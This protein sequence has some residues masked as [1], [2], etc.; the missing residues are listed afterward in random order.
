MGW[1]LPPTGFFKLNTDG[2]ACGSLGMA[3]AGG[4]I[5]DSKGVWVASFNRGIGLTHALVAELWGL[6]DGLALAKNLNIKYLFVETDAQAVVNIINSHSGTTTSH[7]PHIALI[8]NCRSLLQY[9]EEVRISHIHRERNHCEDIL[10]KKGLKLSNML[11]LHSSTPSCIL[12]QLLADAWGVV[13]PHSSIS[14]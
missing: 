5:K 2:F 1:T 3:S 13:Y 14:F 10:A 6:W 12:Y 7:H 8:S 9:F 11:I 4:L